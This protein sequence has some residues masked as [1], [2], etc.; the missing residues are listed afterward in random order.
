MGAGF[1][2]QGLRILVSYLYFPS[3]YIPILNTLK[4]GIFYFIERKVEKKKKKIWE[5]EKT[6]LINPTIFYLSIYVL[7][8]IFYGIYLCTPFPNI[9]TH[10]YAH[11]IYDVDVNA[12]A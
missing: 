9:H 2:K 11:I 6:T 10:V 3:S 5:E 7:D 8:M 1:I 4:H 12:L